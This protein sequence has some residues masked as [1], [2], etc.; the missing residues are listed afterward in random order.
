LNGLFLR[1]N[2][3]K[4]GLAQNCG[5]DGGNRESRAEAALF[6]F[7]NSGGNLVKGRQIWYTIYKGNHADKKG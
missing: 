2:A 1:L 6:L 7:S 4:C 5:A 3:E